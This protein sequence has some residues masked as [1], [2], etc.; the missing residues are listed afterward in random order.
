MDA[1]KASDWFREL[2]SDR[3]LD[4]LER[5]TVDRPVHELSS[6]DAGCQMIAAC[7]QRHIEEEMLSFI[8]E[9]ARRTGARHLYL[10]GGAALNIHANARV[11][12]ELGSAL[13]M[14]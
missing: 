8:G 9:H 6:D 11:E 4:A 10:S 1:L 3:L 7:M 5:T 14:S 2:R 13:S 12:R